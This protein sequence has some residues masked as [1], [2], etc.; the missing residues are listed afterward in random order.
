DKAALQ[1]VS[2]RAE[3]IHHPGRGIAQQAPDLGLALCGIRPLLDELRRVEILQKQRIL[4]DAST[5]LR[6]RGRHIL[7]IGDMPGGQRPPIVEPEEMAATEETLAA[8]TGDH[9]PLVGMPLETRAI[10]RT[11]PIVASR[12]LIRLVPADGHQPQLRR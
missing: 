1:E 7:A 4:E 11:A 8:D 2:G 5:E 3:A 10:Y 6:K 12:I 9:H